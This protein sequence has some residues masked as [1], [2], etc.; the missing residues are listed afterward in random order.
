M[1]R[2]YFRLKT[3]VFFRFIIVNIFYILHILNQRISNCF[4]VL[5]KTSMVLF[6]NMSLFCIDFIILDSCFDKRPQ[7]HKLK[8]RG[9]CTSRADIMKLVCQNTCGLCETK[10][11]GV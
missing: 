5:N 6:I 8:A 4:T 10:D 9:Y 7:C 11:T 2:Q 1:H 3:D